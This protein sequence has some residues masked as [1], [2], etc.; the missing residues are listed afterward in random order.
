MHEISDDSFAAFKRLAAADPQTNLMVRRMTADTV[1]KFLDVLNEDLDQL[2]QSIQE[3]K[4]IYCDA[5]EDVI[6]M[7]IVDLLK[8][9][10]YYAEHDPK[11]GGHVDILVRGR[12]PKFLWLGEAKRDYGPKWLEEGMEQ[13][14]NRYADGSAGRDYGGMLVYIQGMKAAQIFKN[15]REALAASTQFEDLQVTD[16]TR[17]MHAAFNSTHTHNTSGLPYHVRHMAVGLYHKPTK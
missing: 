3:R 4:Q 14:S 6:S 5:E 16:C 8:Q 9:R 15:W 11:I 10:Q 7:A 17:N 12:D 1:D 13:L 2:I